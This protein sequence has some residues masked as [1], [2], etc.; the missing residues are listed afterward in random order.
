M[1]T[2]DSEGLAFDGKVGC[3]MRTRL[4]T[5]L[6]FEGEAE[7]AMRFYASIFDDAEIE[8]IE[9]V[10]EAGPG[11]PGTVERATLRLGQQQVR[12]ID[13]VVEHDFGFT[14]AASL[15]V[16]CESV[17]EVDAV[18]AALAEGGK[19]LMPLGEYAFG[20][21]FAWI[22]D[23]FGVSWQLNFAAISIRGH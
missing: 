7:K 19:V 15:F 1:S 11:T 12:F 22:T 14:P 23:R 3:D 16:E 5:Q 8:Q 17:A 6:M 10:D 4:T 21:R 9:H 2:N 13:S 18:F 20:S